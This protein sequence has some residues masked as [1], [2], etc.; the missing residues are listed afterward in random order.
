[1]EIKDR[2]KRRNGLEGDYTGALRLY[3]GREKGL[4][5]KI[6]YKWDEKPKKDGKTDGNA[7][8]SLVPI[9]Q[10]AYLSRHSLSR[11]PSSISFR[12][13]LVPTQA[14]FTS[15]KHHPPSSSL[16]PRDPTR[17]P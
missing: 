14:L 9:T 8:I 5:G 1:V 13:T 10:N 15:L 2:E 7:L 16:A 6:G 17:Q 4:S 11:T 12:T 3:I